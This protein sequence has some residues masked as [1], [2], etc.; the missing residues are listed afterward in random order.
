ML[1]LAHALILG[2]S[3]ARVAIVC[4]MVKMFSVGVMATERLF[5]TLSFICA[6]I[7]NYLI[8]AR[9]YQQMAKLFLPEKENHKTHTFHSMLNFA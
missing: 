9:Q 5:L 4:F 7:A 1:L 2:G 3:I 8:I 6:P